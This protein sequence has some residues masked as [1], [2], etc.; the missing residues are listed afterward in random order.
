MNK[1]THFPTPNT[2]VQTRPTAQAVLTFFFSKC[3]EAPPLNLRIFCKSSAQ[4]WSPTRKRNH[5]IVFLFPA[6]I[7][8]DEGIGP[9]SSTPS[10]P[11]SGSSDKHPGISSWY[12]CLWGNCRV[13]SE[14]LGKV[15]KSDREMA[16]DK[17]NRT[18]PLFFLFNPGQFVC[19]SDLHNSTD[20]KNSRKKV[21][22]C[23]G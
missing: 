11:R 10:T 18:W 15:S 4:K 17:T 22:L 19:S 8:S 6:G 7:E 12:W 20:A 2:A 14:M 3:K 16:T 1:K 21:C 23:S 13:H 9:E 5:W